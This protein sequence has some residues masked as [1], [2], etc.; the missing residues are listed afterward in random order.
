MCADSKR[1][2][3]IIAEVK[4]DEVN[5]IS[6]RRPKKIGI[7]KNTQK[8]TIICGKA[9]KSSINIIDGIEMILIPDHLAIPKIDPKIKLK[10][11]D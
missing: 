9:R 7:A 4:A 2:K 1:V 3:A 8:I 11:I 10:I 5:F 6:K